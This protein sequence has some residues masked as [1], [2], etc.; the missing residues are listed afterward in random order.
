MLSTFS[1]S[2][3][4]DHGPGSLRQAIIDA[5]DNANTSGVPDEID[6][7]IAGS[8]LHVISP[9][10][11][12][13]PITDPVV[14]DGYTQPGS[15]PNS[16]LDGDSATLLIVLDGSAYPFA[17]GLQLYAG[18]TTVRGLVING[19]VNGIE[20]SSFGGNV[21]EG[22][23]IGTDA[24]GL[25]DLGNTDA[26]IDIRDSPDNRIGGTIPEA[27]NVIAGTKVSFLNTGQGIAI[28][29]ESSV[30][31]LVQGN[32]IGTDATGTL[33]LGNGGDGILV[34]S[35][36]LGGGASETTIRG[37]LISG[38]AVSGI[39]ILGGGNNLVA[40]NL[41]GTDITASE[42]LG[43]SHD[44][45]V[46]DDTT[47]AG[48]IVDTT[49]HNTVG[50]TT[51]TD[52]NVIS[53]NDAN[54]LV[55]VGGTEVGNVVLGN[56]IG[57]NLTGTVALGNGRSGVLISAAIGTTASASHNTIGGTATGA[58]NIISGNAQDGVL[59]RGDD[60]GGTDNV[61]QGNLI[62]TDRTGTKDLGNVGNGVRIDLSASKN[63]IGGTADGA[64]NTIAFNGANG[65]L[66]GSG[67]GNGILSNSIF[68]NVKLGSDL[69][70]D[71]ETLND[72]TDADS[73]A[74]NLQNAPELL[75][76]TT[77]GTSLTV[78]VFRL[79]S[80]PNTMF[81]IE[82][83][84]NRAKDASGA[85]DFTS[86]GEG[87]Q[88]ITYVN[89]PT[90]PTGNVQFTSVLNTPL[91]AGEFVTATA[92]DPD[93]NT[94][95]FTHDADLDGLFDSWEMTGID[96]NHD[97]TID[98]TLSGASPLHKDVF[99]EV[100]AM[101][102][103][104]PAQET[105]DRVVTAFAAA[106]HIFNPDGKGGVHLVALLDETTITPAPW[107]ALDANGW[108]TGFDAIKQNQ[109]TDVIG[110][111]GTLE[112]RMDANWVNI[113]EAK[114]QA[115]RYCI[116][117]DRFGT[118]S[119]SGISELPG[120]DFLVTLGAWR[121]PGGT[122][123]QQAG[124][125]MHELG[126]TLGLRHGGTDDINN[127]PNYYSV[128]NY[129][130]Q[131]PHSGYSSD[132]KLD[133]SDETMPTL[134]ENNLDESNGIGGEAGKLVPIGPP[135]T[136]NGYRVVSQTGPVDWSNLLNFVDGDDDDGDDDP[137]D[138]TGVV[139]DINHI[140]ASDPASP[141]EV[142]KGHEDW[143]TLIYSFRNSPDFADG[144]HESAEVNE[145]LVTDFFDSQVEVGGNSQ[146]IAD[147]DATPDM[148]DG[149]DFGSTQANGGAV[150][151]SFTV[152]NLGNAP[153]DLTGS[154]RVQIGGPDAGDFTV[155]AEPSATL[156]E[157][158]S[159]AFVVTFAPHAPGTRS[160]TITIANDDS[161]ASLY[162][163][164][165]AGLG[166]P[167]S[168][169]IDNAA[170]TEGDS[171]TVDA[172]FTVS[173]S[174]ASSKPVAVDFATRDGSATAP[175]DYTAIPTTTLTFAPGETSKPITVAVKGDTLDESDETF[176]VQ[177]GNPTNATLA[178]V[179]GVGTIRD[180][181]TAGTLQFD[182]AALSV[183]RDG[184]SIMIKVDRTGGY[185]S[186]VTVH[187]ATS[188][189]TAHAGTD[190]SAAAGTLTYGAGDLS[191]TF[192]VAILNNTLVTGATTVNLT[193]YDPTGGA[194]L[195]GASGSPVSSMS[196]VSVNSAGTGSGNSDSPWRFADSPSVLVSADGRYVVFTSSA[197]DL[198]TSDNNGTGVSVG[199]GGVT[200]ITSPI[201]DNNGNVDVFERD[202]LLGTTTLVSVDSAGTASGSG[203][204]DDP[205]VSADGRFVLFESSAPDLV[206]GYDPS[207]STG[208]G[209]GVRGIGLFVHD[210]QSGVTELVSVNS[211]GAGGPFIRYDNGHNYNISA[212]GRF[213]VFNSP[214]AGFVA[215]DN[216]LAD[217]VF[218]RD[219]VAHTTSLVSVSRDGAST[220][221]L[222]SYDPV[223]CADG[224]FVAF[225]SAASNLVTND[226]NDYNGG[227]DIYVRDLQTGLT[228]VVTVN[229]I[230]DAS[231]SGPESGQSYVAGQFAI[232][233]VGR[234]VVFSSLAPNLVA[235]DNNDRQ[236]VFE[237]DLLLGT[238]TLVSVTS[239]GTGSANQ[240]SFMPRVSS[241]GRFVAFDSDAGDLV[242]D[243]T[244]RGVGDVFVRD[245]IGGTTTLVSVNQTG[246]GD[247]NDGSTLE[248]L[249]AD[250]R[251]VAFI[252]DANDFVAH[253]SNGRADIF[254]RDLLSHTTALISAPRAGTD[255]AAGSSLDGQLS[256]DGSTIVFVSLAADLAP[257][258]NNG[259]RD[260]FAAHLQAPSAAVL[261]I[262][263]AKSAPS[264]TSTGMSI[265]PN[266]PT[267]G[268]IV[269]DNVPGPTVKLLQRYGYHAQPTTLVL[270]LSGALDP[271][272]AENVGNYRIVPLGLW[273]KHHGR[274]I[275]V[276]A[277]V[278]DLASRT[279]TLWP[280]ERLNIHW[281]YQLT[282]RGAASGG[283][284][285][286][287]AVRLGAVGK[288]QPGVDYVHVIDW[289]TLAGSEFARRLRFHARRM[290][291]R[292]PM[293]SLRWLCRNN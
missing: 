4:L 130:W 236:D 62:G 265:P 263:A 254:V 135:L 255:S 194:S 46:I 19:F 55:I 104:A 183:A 208:F 18:N 147:G 166:V 273:W 22:N 60:T 276:R 164:V 165:V 38:N 100:D 200:V 107:T 112:E 267:A 228:T 134:D 14:I 129:A 225:V 179:H 247:S 197:S 252:S 45:V 86:L 26:G 122:P 195:G 155:T 189:G 5:N 168:I 268:V 291:V 3:I 53:G 212:D 154:P 253:D 54:G 132:W 229:Q 12:L 235:N 249:S 277:A 178:E 73:G 109:S 149:T 173:L 114:R 174:A 110:G 180:D 16:V 169:S 7:D 198:V 285:G 231:G 57:T 36:G 215:S 205:R 108:P 237:R 69:G 206:A 97:G 27:R 123:D 290:R 48:A 94:S 240:D 156:G 63:T 272:R 288:G 67:T 278:Y 87:G 275:A 177:L 287:T 80:T 163:F 175:S 222:G 40:G 257:A 227:A 258:D 187:F 262:A 58:G 191:Q 84:F 185:A 196:L 211:A 167:V 24:T 136:D 85:D 289:R 44:G 239:A 219:L 59:I 144:S 171:G 279:V 284:T 238:T 161:A 42:D 280:A 115:Y 145:Q 142:L 233:S 202:L 220:G 117:G 139:A 51:E 95:E 182:Q 259:V 192:T 120:N 170:V 146:P 47:D 75:A 17:D 204:S 201:S 68:S 242:A 8:G 111:F 248:G 34:S 218:V 25:V 184:G 283:L 245:V 264:P 143:S 243:G 140:H 209:P 32:F 79:D 2:N 96:S 33:A 282:V 266:S 121:L 105:L 203:D 1:V 43:N 193:L 83:F 125:F 39:E 88:F 70:D 260:V 29:G 82:F 77:N 65:V 234:Y 99:V 52:R 61:V 106:P 186:D 20:V 210:M 157:G 214:Y 160:A 116:F 23:F 118:Q 71:G 119:T 226:N 190:Y 10:T 41:I 232:S 37:N 133:Y 74:N 50:G 292:P 78:V 224:R 271:A 113:R 21:I 137:L 216:N 11:G 9:L 181:D 270:N 31:N 103:R 207:A 98:L 64:G 93:N 244:S 101:L 148:S 269:D 241:D 221:N 126:H 158:G 49:G 76:V 30:R 230:G 28:T 128:M 199:G 150:T 56:F 256:A 138:D 159:T 152:S 90:D 35:A 91:P 131:V 162:S 274:P 89:A 281:P 13:P 124:T 261:T 176:F 188:D 223:I 81:R 286:A 72:K 141:G 102:G 246:T 92:T 250:G 66:V 217:D 15:S 151:R 172:T 6:F 293:P 153:L 213:V 127:K 251:F